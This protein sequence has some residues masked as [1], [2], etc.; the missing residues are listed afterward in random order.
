MVICFPAD[1]FSPDFSYRNQRITPVFHQSTCILPLYFVRS[2]GQ[3]QCRRRE[4][5]HCSMP[6][7][8]PVVMKVPGNNRHPTGHGHRILRLTVRFQVFPLMNWHG[9]E[10][11]EVQQ[12]QQHSLSNLHHLILVSRRLHS[13][14]LSPSLGW[15]LE[16]QVSYSL[17][18]L[19]AIQ[20]NLHLRLRVVSYAGDEGK[21]PSS[22]CW[23]LMKSSDPYYQ[24]FPCSTPTHY[25]SAMHSTRSSFSHPPQQR[26]PRHST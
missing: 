15:I 19:L 10:G 14:V 24:T 7:L 25:L 26:G 22:N 2:C 21:S 20:I 4:W 11:C 13:P 17:I 18:D 1:M 12:H 8:L 5:E 3:C 6:S 9:R 23:I 16:I